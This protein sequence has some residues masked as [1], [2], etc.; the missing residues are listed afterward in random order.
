[1]LRLKSDLVPALIAARDGV[2]KSFDLR[3]RDDAALT[4][5]M[6]ANGYP[7]TYAKGS[8]IAGLDEAAAV[9][10]VEIF[11]AGTATGADGNAR[12][13]WRTRAQCLGDRQDGRRGAGA[14]LCG[15]RQDPLARRASAAATSA[16]ARSSGRQALSP[17][18]RLGCAVYIFIALRYIRGADMGVIIKNPATEKKIRRLAKRTGETLTQ[19]VERAVDERLAR[20]P[21]PRRKGR[22]DR[23]KLAELLAYFNSLPV[24]DP[25]SPDEIIGYNEYGAPE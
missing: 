21:A 23:A 24:D 3:W 1:M 18:L 4:V 15:G 25:R 11:H 8:A 10:G 7:G 6:A 12:R 5:V 14:R 9:E 22:I 17:S 16:G 2:L 13:E 20:L 19:A